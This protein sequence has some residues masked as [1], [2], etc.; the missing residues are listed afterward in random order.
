MLSLGAVVLWS[1]VASN[2]AGACPEDPSR[3][4][5]ES[6]YLVQDAASFRHALS[7]AFQQ[8]KTQLTLDRLEEPDHG[9]LRPAEPSPF[10]WFETG[11]LH[12]SANVAGPAPST[13][14]H[15]PHQSPPLQVLH[16]P[17]M[18]APAALGGLQPPD[19]PRHEC[20]IKVRG[21]QQLTDL[22]LASAALTH[23][24]Q[25]PVALGPNDRDVGHKFVVLPEASYRR[26]FAVVAT[27]HYIDPKGT[28]HLTLESRQPSGDK[29]HMP[30]ESPNNP[31]PPPKKGNKRPGTKL[32]VPKGNKQR[33]TEPAPPG[34]AAA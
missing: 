5:K 21:L 3:S 9:A 26:Q 11:H 27:R 31:P 4:T 14:P 2:V 25:T 29:F 13:Y 17:A 32:K 6:L 7:E 12:R 20:V 30:H 15:T 28:F 16:M 23:K 33:T 8:T 18:S 10:A 1:N 19:V 34:A 22:G 24:L